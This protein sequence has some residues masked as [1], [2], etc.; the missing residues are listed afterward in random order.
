V[1]GVRPLVG[2]VGIRPL[3]SGDGSA[4][5]HAYVRNREHLARWEPRRTESWFTERGQ[6]ENV[7]RRLAERE[8]GVTLAWVLVDGDSVV[9]TMTVSGIVRGPFLSGSLG[10]WVDSTRTGRGVA[11]AAVAYALAAC[12][13]DGLHR[14]QA[15]TLL[16]NAASQAVLRRNGFDA[17]GVARGYLCIAG[18]WQDHLLFERL[19]EED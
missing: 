4:L 15:G 11:A 16:H 6:D 5:A 13:K 1:A 2:T 8:Q 14:L 3:R 19:L 7:A 17:I 10:Y 9:G 12:R 18:S